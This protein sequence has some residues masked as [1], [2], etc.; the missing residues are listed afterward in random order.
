MNTGHHVVEVLTEPGWFADPLGQHELRYFDGRTWTNHVTHNGPKPCPGC[1]V[2][3]NS[4]AEDAPLDAQ[5]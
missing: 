3:D 5:I 4:P 1:H 2:T